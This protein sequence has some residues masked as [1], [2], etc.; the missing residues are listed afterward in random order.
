[1]EEQHQD[2]H[3]TDPQL[4]EDPDLKILIIRLTE[5]VDRLEKTLTDHI[6]FIDT[7]YEGLK[8]PLNFIMSS[9]NNVFLLK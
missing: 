9:V 8:R 7:I 1:M 6:S 3:Q 4:N 5:K 2:Q